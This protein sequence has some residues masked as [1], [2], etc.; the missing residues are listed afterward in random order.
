[1]ETYLAYFDILGFKEY[2]FNTTEEDVSRKF[3]HLFR[4]SQRAQNGDAWITESHGGQ[5]P[6]FRYSKANC[7]HISDSIIFWTSGVGDQHFT[8]IIEVCNDF[9]QCCCV[10][11]LCPVRGCV[12][13]GDISFDPFIINPQEEFKFINSSLY[14]KALIDAYL[15]AEA[16]DWAG[17]YIDKS[18]Y[19]DISKNTIDNLIT[20]GKLLSYPVPFKNGVVSNELTVKMIGPKR[21][22][23]N[24]NDV[25]NLFTKQINCNAITDSIQR[26]IDNTVQYFN[27]I[28][29]L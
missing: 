22:N 8:N 7:L 12:V 24:V 27:H 20:S 14:G 9:F 13:K 26:K 25:E 6:D 10:N 19:D 17:C 29:S 3:E 28:K 15:K 4:D 16:Q 5:V 11:Q 18:A 23:I 2:I 1:M 21:D